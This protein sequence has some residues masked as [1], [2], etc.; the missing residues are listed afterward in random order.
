M[1]KVAN[2]IEEGRWGGPQRRISLVADRARGAGIYTVVLL[3]KYDSEEFQKTLTDSK[4]EYRAL[5]IHR[6]SRKYTALILY[7]FTIL[8]DVFF[9]YR[10]LKKGKYDLLHASGGAWQFKG[11]VA[12]YL[13]GVKVV[14]HL[15]DSSMPTS[16][17]QIFRLL[18]R[19]ADAFFI[20]A[21]KSHDH[22]LLNSK[23]E[24]RQCFLIPAPVDTTK[25]DPLN[26]IGNAD[27]ARL[28]FPR[29]LTVGNINPIKGLEILVETAIELKKNLEEFS[30]IIVGAIL[31]TQKE[32]Y[33]QL[34]NK[35][36]QE[37]L[38]G[39]IHFLGLRQDIPEIMAAC[40][41][42]VCSSHAESSP[43]SVWEAM[44]MEMAVI[45][46]DV[47][48]VTR[49]LTAGS[50]GE[51]I[52]PGDASMLADKLLLLSRDSKL[53]EKLGKKARARVIKTLDLDVISE[54]TARAYSQVAK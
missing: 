54:K 22:Y 48:D 46:T 8:T 50:D 42:Y 41:I 6:L 3:P 34:T 29:I 37:E 40:D 47:G 5:P 28:P 33:L 18:G 31:D 1:L 53:R 21:K 36:R 14:W 27:I 30:I 9:I 24:N 43:M 19:Y 12:A 11:P 7:M 32:Y 16:V 39:Y 15:N 45:S 44:S 38:T 35:I 20:S 13:A 25:F 49:N 10:E 2:I 17:I 23:L 26:T 52:E 51:I 4:V